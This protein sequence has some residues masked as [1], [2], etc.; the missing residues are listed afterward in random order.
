MASLDAKVEEYDLGKGSFTYLSP[1]QLRLTFNSPVVTPVGSYGVQVLGNSGQSLFEKKDL[2][3][4]I[5][6][7]WVA[8]VQVTPPVRAGGQSTLKVLGRD[9][10]DAFAASF[11]IELDEPRIVISNLRRADPATLTADIHVDPG[12]APGDYWLH[13]SAQGQKIEPPFGSI[14]RVESAQ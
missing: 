3:K 11:H 12:V 1:L 2:F 6:P 14:I 10:S 7:N 13:L 8:G 9:F 5:P 4:I